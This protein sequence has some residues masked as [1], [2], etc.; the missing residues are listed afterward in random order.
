MPKGNE[1]RDATSSSISIR[2]TPIS[3]V[4]QGTSFIMGGPDLTTPFGADL[5]TRVPIQSEWDLRHY[6][7]GPDRTDLR[8]TCGMAV[9]SRGSRMARRQ[10]KRLFPH[11]STSQSYGPTWWGVLRARGANL[12][13]HNVGPAKFR[14]AIY[15]GE[16]RR[17]NIQ[18]APAHQSTGSEK[19]LSERRRRRKEKPS[20]QNGDLLVFEA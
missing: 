8:C 19:G 18:T 15:E 12:L 3:F 17:V 9:T 14:V 13:G 6:R 5:P 16:S 1:I 7:T 2:E 20:W 10:L 11:P 4:E